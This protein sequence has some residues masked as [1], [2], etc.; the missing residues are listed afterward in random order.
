MLK[1]FTLPFACVFSGI[2]IAQDPP[3]IEWQRAFGGSSSD[4]PHSMIRTT[5]GGY[6]LAGA[7]QSFDGDVMGNHGAVDAW[8][9]KI[10]VNWGFQWQKCLGG[11]GDEYVRSLQ[12]TVDGGYMLLGST[13]STDGDVTGNHG[14]YD[15]WVVKLDENGSIDWE[16]CLGGSGEDYPTS[17]QQ[18]TD[19]GYI[20]G[21][22]T[23]STD[24]DVTGNHGGVDMWVLKLTGNGN[25]DWQES[26]GGSATESLMSIQQTPDD[27]YILAGFANSDNGDVSENHGGDDIWVVKL[28]ENGTIDWQKSL[29]GSSMDQGGTVQHT[30]DGGY[31]VEGY[32]NSTDGDVTV[33]HGGLDIW[34]IKL[35]ESGD[36]QWQ[37]SLGGSN[38][39]FAKSVQQTTDGGYVVVSSAVLST[40]GDVTG[41][42]GGGDI[43][44]VKLL[45]NGAIEWQ[46]C[47]GG[48]GAEEVGSIR[49]T[50][51]GGYIM[52]GSTGSVDG[53]VSGNH[54]NGDIWVV[55]LQG[56]GT[57]EWQTCLGG[58]YQDDGYSIEQLSGSEYVLLGQVFSIDGDVTEG[59]G[60][61]DYWVVKLNFTTSIPE[62]EEDLEIT[63][64]PNPVG[65]A[66][67]LKYT[68]KEAVRMRIQLV[69]N[70]GQ[71]ITTLLEGQRTT[72]EHLV[73]VPMAALAAG[74][75][76]LQFNSNGRP[77]SRELVK[78]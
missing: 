73:Q 28:F 66:A 36:I 60:F 49:P 75:Y 43:W 21:G 53:D 57:I 15:I 33:V 55:R 61:P 40:D 69:N 11:S 62:L 2:L 44:V 70:K 78:H 13:N 67:S 24:G 3:V 14:G 17:I 71:V 1:P 12:Q 30:L 18:T 10:D 32:T 38:D 59:H 51:D 46:A 25:V 72:G 31:L 58:S 39:E 65:D 64:F 74:V 37:R 56:T 6:L 7:T 20:V 26:L 34:L 35:N 47:L 22:S 52:I 16:K 50:M 5:D 68:L 76:H 41:N 77:L 45:G 8:V 54:G 19:G 23:G 27:G 29:G 9:V 42:H 4:E 63:L 48:T